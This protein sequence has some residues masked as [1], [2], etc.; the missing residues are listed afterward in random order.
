MKAKLM[1]MVVATALAF[2]GLSLFAG[3]VGTEI[4]AD[5]D[6]PRLRQDLSEHDQQGPG[7]LGL[8]RR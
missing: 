4:G 8:A 2:S 1:R 3:V 7:L 5:G 6:A